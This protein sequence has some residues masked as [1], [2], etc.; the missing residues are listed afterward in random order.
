MKKRNLNLT[1]TKIPPPLNSS[2]SKLA[3]FKTFS[4]LLG[5]IL[6]FSVLAQ[7]GDYADIFADLTKKTSRSAAFLERQVAHMT[8]VHQADTQGV[9]SLVNNDE[10]TTIRTYTRNQTLFNNYL[11]QGVNI[12][13]FVN[14]QAQDLD[15]ALSKLPD[16]EEIT[17]RGIIAPKGVFGTK[18]IAN[19]VV[20][21][22]LF[23]STSSSKEYP[24]SFALASSDNAG[25]VFRIEGKTGKNIA[26][27]SRFQGIKG[28]AEV[29]FRPNTQFRVLDIKK[30][31]GKTYVLL[32]QELN[33]VGPA[34]RIF[35]GDP[36]NIAICG[37]N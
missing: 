6:S 4:L 32:K 3:Q 33:Y 16:F 22:N 29:L 34:K 21:N 13:H 36:I 2:L 15:M 9:L 25:V 26:L 12:D 1:N 17:Y 20:S 8:L 7:P 30:S 35:D 19:D 24:K 28:E 11:K 23:M 5:L 37:I 18:I 31:A 27:F 10:Y 14:V